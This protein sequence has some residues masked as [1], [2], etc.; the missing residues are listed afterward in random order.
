MPGGLGDERHVA[1]CGLQ[2]AVLDR[3][4]RGAAGPVP[5]CGSRRRSRGAPFTGQHHVP[6][7]SVMSHMP[8]GGGSMPCLYGSAGTVARI[9]LPCPGR[10]ST[11]RVPPTSRARSRIESSPRWPGKVPCESK[12]TPSSATVSVTVPGPLSRWRV[13]FRARAEGIVALAPVNR[14]TAYQLMAAFSQAWHLVMAQHRLQT[15]DL[16]HRPEIHPAR[17]F[18]LADRAATG[19]RCAPC[20]SSAAGGSAAP[21]PSAG[22][23]ESSATRHRPDSL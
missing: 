21:P 20:G 7:G 6:R 2:Q 4:Q 18:S 16:F 22:C 12:P 1:A 11:S 10:L 14:T 23:R 19:R 9:R 3:R 8:L 17:H 5:A 15:H 13:T